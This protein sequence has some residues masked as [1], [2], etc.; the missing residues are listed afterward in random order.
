MVMATAFDVLPA[1]DLR[2][3]RVVRLEAGDFERETA[4]GDDPTSVAAGFTRD[5]ASWLHVVDLDA[6][7]SGRPSHTAAIAGIIESVGDRVRVEVA[8]G[9]RSEAAV[10]TTLEAGAARAVVGTAAIRDAAF[11]GRLVAVHG[12]ARITVAIDV[13]D[14]RAVGEAW[15][16]ADPGVDAEEAIRRLADAGVEI[17]EVT[18]IERDGL[19]AGPNLG[20]YE[21]LVEL[22]RG[23][24]IASG[25]IATVADLH[26]LRAIGCAGA[27][28]GRA[29]YE[30]RLSLRDA[31]TAE[32]G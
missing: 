8:G 16:A 29:L 22:D 19:L 14:D 15:S 6:A 18:A 28:I 4:F 2:G 7:R 30:G 31:L 25:G 32:G 26:A 20:L 21:R 5:G 3:G 24:V 12:P 10:A 23:A 17:F 13:R 9:L 1:I 11:A 27:I